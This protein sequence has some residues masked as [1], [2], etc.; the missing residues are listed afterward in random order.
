M[1]I[2]SFSLN[3]RLTIFVLMFVLLIMGSYAYYSLP[4]ESFPDIE[5]PFIVV[6]TVYSGVSPADIESLVTKKIEKELQ[7][8]DD[9]KEILST[10][11]EGASVISIEFI[12]DTDIDDALQKVKDKVDLAQPELP[13]DAEEPIVQ[14]LSMADYPIMIVALSGDYS[15]V[16][17]KDI[18]EDIEEEIE[19][20]KGVLDVDIVGGLDRE[21]K[22]DIDPIRMRKYDL[23][24]N[25]II[26]K[27]SSENVTLPGGSV[28]IGKLNYT[29][30]I[31]GEF[32]NTLPIKTLIVKVH[33]G[34]PVYIRDIADVSFGYK[35][36]SSYARLN[37]KETISLNI[38][39][40][41]GENIIEIADKV[42]MVLKKLEPTFPGTTKYSILADQS[43]DIRTMVS[44]LENNI[45]SGF[46]LVV[47]V[48]MLF[49]GFRNSLFVAIAMPFSMLIAFLVIT[50]IGLTLNMVVLFSLILALGMLVDNAIVV[51]ENIFRHRQE[52]MSRYEA[53]IKGT[54]EVAGPVIASTVTTLCAFA[55]LIFWPGIMG[56]FMNYLP[57][58]LI[59]TLIASLFVALVFN[60]VLCSVFM[61]LREKDYIGKEHKETKLLQHYRKFLAYA[62]DHRKTVF[63]SAFVLLVAVIVIY[64]ILGKGAEFMP[65][66]DPKKIFI[67]VDAPSGTRLETSDQIVRQ[68]EKVV[69][70][71][72]DLKDYIANIGSK[73][74]GEVNFGAG[75]NGSSNLSRVTLEFVDY[76]DRKGNTWDVMNKVRKGIEF[77][78]GAVIKVKEQQDGP[79]TGAPVNIEISGDDFAILGEISEKILKEIENVEG[80]VN[81]RDDYDKGRP[82]IRVTV[83]REKAALLNLSTL[84]IAS[85]VR[86]A[87]Y[88]TEASK[89]RQG[90][91]E[92][93]IRVRAKEEKRKT[94]SDVKNIFIF[95][96]GQKI[97][98]TSVATVETASGLG[99]IKRKDRKRMVTIT[100]DNA[101]GYLADSVLK[102]V[103]KK[104]EHFKLPQGYSIEYT[105]ESEDKEEASAFLSKAFVIVIFLIALVLIFQFDSLVLPFTIIFSVFLSLIGVLI[106]LIV[107]GTPF[108]IIMTGLGVIS[109]AGVVVN[110]AIVLIDYI[111]QLRKRGIEKREAIIQ[112]GIVR[113]RPVMLT[114]VTTILGLIPLTTGLT[115]DFTN[116]KF[117]IGGESSEW[118]GPMGVAVIFGLAFAT[119]LTLVMVP[120][121]YSTLD[122]L[123][124]RAKEFFGKEDKRTV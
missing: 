69:A 74:D 16:K 34:K 17:L 105:G 41:S 115:F 39:K 119:V 50:A 65:K 84:E 78:P 101:P 76:H 118:W 94:I 80:V 59:I 15:L 14:E 67:D 98:L 120:V 4:R 6:T 106:G 44:E 91:D 26:K 36:Q 121:M 113:F 123:E 43:K 77:I 85:T 83:N 72:P 103:Q 97:P 111:R 86:T 122:A 45:V 82:E 124:W 58:T 107:T 42:R 116:F 31:P 62:L 22:I 54:E 95:K 70:V 51:V 9:V 63:F 7:G 110:N 87:V 104:L 109:L 11:Y 28:K 2:I 55:P 53:A 47:L 23:S 96:E 32:E 40:R 100:G 64:G 35:E 30:R 99:S 38:Q 66:I 56:K 5:I 92:Y 8:L 48:L 21:V 37:G 52:G 112:A 27:I 19:A 117:L 79:P 73:G 102:K 29:V 75:N 88:G 18:A 93:D 24:Y 90:E 89:F 3:N 108:G 1:N 49:L 46:F 20:I 33:N 12:A 114:A 13:E 25:D 60:P 81:L 71:Q 68:I 10:S 61:R 57:K